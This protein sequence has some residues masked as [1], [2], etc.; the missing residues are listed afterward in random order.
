MRLEPR[1]QV[2]Q[3]DQRGQQEPGPKVF[4]FTHQG[5]CPRIPTPDQGTT[6]GFGP[7]RNDAGRFV[8]AVQPCILGQ[9]QSRR[10]LASPTT[11]RPGADSQRGS[12]E[13][14]R[15]RKPSRATR[16]ARVAW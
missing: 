10:K 15:L 2:L 13:L 4:D 1:A 3:V 8:P 16:V 11:A 14:T 6:F 5:L 7:H 12:R 9:R